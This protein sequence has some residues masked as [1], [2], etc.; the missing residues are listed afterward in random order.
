MESSEPVVKAHRMEA[1]ESIMVS[2]NSDRAVVAVPYSTFVVK[3][4]DPTQPFTFLSTI[5]VSASLCRGI[6]PA[7]ISGL[8]LGKIIIGN[9]RRQDE[10]SREGQRNYNLLESFANH[11]NLLALN[12]YSVPLQTISGLHTMFCISRASIRRHR[13]IAIYKQVSA[14]ARIV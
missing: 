1:P 12:Y 7:K 9:T 13:Q 10:T 11:N 8:C 4:A 14:Q 3:T 6:W 2:D 5:P